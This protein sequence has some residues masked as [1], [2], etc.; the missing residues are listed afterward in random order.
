MSSNSPAWY[1]PG[2]GKQ[3]AGPFTAEQLIQSWRAGK[4]SDRTMCWREG[5]TQWLPLVQAEPFASAIRA[6]TSP[7]PVTGVSTS[8]PLPRAPAPAFRQPGIQEGVT[9]RRWH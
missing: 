8:Q 4:I 5:M 7:S 6:A 9:L 3:P 2:E 1:L